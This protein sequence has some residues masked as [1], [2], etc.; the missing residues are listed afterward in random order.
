MNCDIKSLLTFIVIV[1]SPCLSTRSTW[2]SYV[3]V[4]ELMLLLQHVP[5]QTNTRLIHHPKIDCMA[6]VHKDG[7]LSMECILSCNWK[8]FPHQQSMMQARCLYFEI[9]LST[10]EDVEWISLN[11]ILHLYVFLVSASVSNIFLCRNP[12]G[13]AHWIRQ[14]KRLQHFLDSPSQAASKALKGYK[15]ISI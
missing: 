14:A 6:Y 1:S 11:L 12:I 15:N 7:H 13:K 2:I 10:E 5:Y 8:H 3:Y 4:G 9:V